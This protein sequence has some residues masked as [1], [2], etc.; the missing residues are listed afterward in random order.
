VYLRTTEASR[1]GLHRAPPELW[2]RLGGEE[3]RGP[4]SEA[5][6]AGVAD[7]AAVS[8][9]A[10]DS[11]AVET[12]MATAAMTALVYSGLHTRLY[13]GYVQVNRLVYLRTRGGKQ[14][15]S[16]QYA[17]LKSAATRAQAVKFIKEKPPAG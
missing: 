2:P 3:V 17:L 16:P 13:K 4:S 12:L 14:N 5:V 8:A 10:A 11:A 7:T 15:G 6:S 9:G 1:T